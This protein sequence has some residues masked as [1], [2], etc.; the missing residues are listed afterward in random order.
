[1]GPQELSAPP[2]WTRKLATTLTTERNSPAPHGG[3]EVH[4]EARRN[5]VRVNRSTA[6]SVHQFGLANADRF[7]SVPRPGRQGK[8]ALDRCGLKFLCFRNEGLI[9]LQAPT[10]DSRVRLAFRQETAQVLNAFF[11]VVLFDDMSDQMNW[12]SSSLAAR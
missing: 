9:Y 1:M 2:H 5:L 6:E 10:K 11:E 7:E 4:R 3:G 8:T 12:I